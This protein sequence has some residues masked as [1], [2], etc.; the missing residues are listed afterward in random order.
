M[1]RKGI[2]LVELLVGMSIFLI[3]LG[4]LSTFFA[5]NQRVASQQITSGNASL[6]ARQSLLRLN[7]LLFQAAYIYPANQ[8]ITLTVDGTAKTLT[9][10]ASVLAFLIPQSASSPYCTGTAQT[11][12]GFVYSIESRVPFADVL[13]NRTDVTGF[14]LLEHKVDGA[15]RINWSVGTI[16]TRTW[17][18][19]TVGVVADSVDNAI[20]D[21]GS[22]ANLQLSDA[23]K[24]PDGE[25]STFSYTSTVTANALIQSV[26]YTLSIRYNQ[27]GQAISSQQTGY[28][29]SR[30]IPRIALPNP[31]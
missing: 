30:V 7:E 6:V 23:T 14:A 21:L 2:T 1:N 26:N 11:Y 31:N 8:P 13:G 10:G 3:L 24:V 27:R 22:A 18:Q 19:A 4:A 28:T 15:Q 29:F 5:S 9:T 12:C 20:S 25:R 16:P 17:G